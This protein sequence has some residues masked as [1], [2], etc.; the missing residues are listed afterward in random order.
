VD[1]A[2]GLILSHH[3]PTLGSEDTLQLLGMM[4]QFFSDHNVPIQHFHTDNGVF[5][6]S[7]FRKHLMDHEY[8]LSLL[9]VGA[10][11]AIQTVTWKAQ[12]MMIHLQLLW[13]DHFA[14]NVWSFALTHAT[15]IHNH[16]LTDDLGFAPIELFR[17]VHLNCHTLRRVQVFG[18]FAYVLDPRLQDGFK[19]PKWEPW[20]CLGQFHG[21]SS[22][23]S[24][25]IETIRNLCTGYVFPQ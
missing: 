23:H 8:K 9:G 12:T 21:F 24:T 17:G 14:A 2:S 1:N 7:E 22:S 13:P 4:E 11:L 6:S 15:W 3:Q 10:H 20:A 19:I 25:T 16:T 5:T 18:C